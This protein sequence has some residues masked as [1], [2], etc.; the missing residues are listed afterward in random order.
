[1]LIKHLVRL[2]Q[3]HLICA[4]DLPKPAAMAVP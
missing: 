3:A 2:G 1:M 4:A